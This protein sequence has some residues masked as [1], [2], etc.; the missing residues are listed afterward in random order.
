MSTTRFSFTFS[1]S[2]PTPF[3]PFPRWFFGQDPILADALNEALMTAS[4]GDWLH[5]VL[6]R[7][8]DR[9]D[10]NALDFLFE[11]PYSNHLEMDDSTF[12]LTAISPAELPAAIALADAWCTSICAKPEIL[13]TAAE[14]DVQF[15]R[16]QLAAIEHTAGFNSV[17]EDGD[18]VAYLLGFLR[19]LR[20]EMARAG[21]AGE[22]TIHVRMG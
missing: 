20:A 7:V 19:S 15:V 5:F 10:G 12:L 3:G 9:L 16:E 18:D 6:A 11:D 1:R 13:A 14:L 8:R 2:D 22:T 17:S 4:R 21:A